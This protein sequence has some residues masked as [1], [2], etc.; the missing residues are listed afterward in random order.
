M[1]I[2]QFKVKKDIFLRLNEMYADVT[3]SLSSNVKPTDIGS[4]Y[5]VYQDF[6][7]LRT[8]ANEYMDEGGQSSSTGKEHLFTIYSKGFI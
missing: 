3:N 4:I 8:L 2:K 1:Y 5:R 7:T 6:T